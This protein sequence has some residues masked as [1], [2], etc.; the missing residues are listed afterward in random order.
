MLRPRL[1]IGLLY[2]ADLEDHVAEHG[3]SF[4]ALA[5]DV[6]CRR[7]DVMSAVRRLENCIDYVSHWMSANRLKLNTDKTELLW[8]G[9]RHCPA[10]LEARVR[11]HHHHYHH[12]I[13]YSGLSIKNTTRTTVREGRQS[14]D[15][16]YV[17]IAAAEQN[18]LQ[19]L[20][21]HRQ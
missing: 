15:D 11:H 3:I 4:H 20:S 17:R 16:T 19:A 13:F 7:D 9:S 1:F 10:V 14:S 8:A 21:E 2:T 12:I 6:Q 5:D 18:C